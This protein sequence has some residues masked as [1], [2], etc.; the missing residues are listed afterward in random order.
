MAKGLRVAD[1]RT[2]IADA[3][4]ATLA[5][6]GSRGLTHRAVDQAAGLPQGSTSYYLR[7]RLS[8]LETAV[9]RLAELDAAAVPAPAGADISTS[10]A[11][12]VTALLDSGRDRLL[13]RYELT[14]EAARRPELRRAL[15]AG[16]QRVR[17]A[18]LH[19]LIDHGTPD[20]AQRAD[21]VLA[22]VQGLLL[23]EVTRG[24]GTPR[25]AADIRHALETV[26]GGPSEQPERPPDERAG[27]D[28][29]DAPSIGASPGSASHLRIA[30]PSRDLAAAEEFWVR[31]LGMDVLWRTAAAGEEHALLMLGWQHAA[32][33]LELVEDL[34]A[35]QA[36][37][38]TDEDLLVLHLGAPLHEDMAQRLLQAGGV[39]ARPRNPYWQRWGTTYVDPDGYILVLSHRSWS[40]ITP[41]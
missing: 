41:G 29:R 27:V 21:A 8:L 33:H 1:R 4:I 24:R 30:R 36:S 25:S 3:V 5:Q 7:S 9:E 11:A 37:K 13:A 38:P 15:N 17:D 40:W 28:R 35:A 34:D 31:G 6:H 14:L 22:L 39:P 12:A 10:L 26:L 19:R 16:S 32:W 20:A 23:S 18:V 2:S